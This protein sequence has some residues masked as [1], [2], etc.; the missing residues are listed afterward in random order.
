MKKALSVMAIGLASALIAG[1]GSS[2]SPSAGAGA[3]TATGSGGSA[4]AAAATSPAAGARVLPVAKNPIVNTSSAPGL[5]IA[6]V[7]VENNVSAQTG[8]TVS[9]HLEVSLK[10]TTTKP[11]SGLELYYTIS[12]PQTG[13]SE[14]YFTRLTGLVIDPGATKTVN[15]DD[16]AGAD[17]Y[18]VNKYSLYYT[19]KNALVV[20][21]TASA[22]GL[23]VAT[24]T[25][26]KDAGGAEAGVE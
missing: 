12:D 6:K 13:A 14:G 18:P 1:C 19:D 26:K 16:T 10:N 21:V 5:E 2:S 8:K 7:L 15:F 24:F 4:P 9:D 20:D 25:V 22:P 17:H 11:L 23:K 3:T